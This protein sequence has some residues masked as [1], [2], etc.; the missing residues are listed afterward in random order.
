MKT[1]LTRRRLLAL[2]GLAAG[3]TALQ[4]KVAEAGPPVGTLPNVNGVITRLKPNGLKLAT[5]GGEVNVSFAKGST[6]LRDNHIVS[7]AEYRVGDHVIV[8][9][10]SEPP[11][12]EQ[13]SDRHFSGQHM[14]SRFGIIDEAVITTVSD[15]HLVTDKGS[16][17][18]PAPN[19]LIHAPGVRDPLPYSVLV[20]GTEVDIATLFEPAINERI[21]RDIAVY[22]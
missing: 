5:A 14:E 20:P 2:A 12:Q 13:L 8:V 22:V 3:A 1:R 6:F 11:S 4:P 18:W 19:C 7:F 9:G 15:G 16:V 21:A 10:D 17:V